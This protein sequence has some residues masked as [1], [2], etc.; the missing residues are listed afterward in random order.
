MISDIKTEADVQTLVDA[1]Y[2]KVQNDELISKYFAAT[3]WQNHLPKMY[4]FW[5]SLIFL[6]GKYK[7]FPFAAH[8][9]LPGLSKQHF[10][11]WLQIFLQNVDEYFAG[12][13]AD[14]MKNKAQQIATVFML[15]LGIYEN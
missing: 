4:D 8:A 3:D 1:F 10:E 7:G 15:R 9:G 2:L 12:E 6:T 14:V 13:N 11:R 5:H